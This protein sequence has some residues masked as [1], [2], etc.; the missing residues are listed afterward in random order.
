M[1]AA[2]LHLMLLRV[3]LFDLLCGYTMWNQWERTASIQ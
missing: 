3:L 2:S 1:K